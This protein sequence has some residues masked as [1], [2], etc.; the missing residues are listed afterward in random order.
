VPRRIQLADR[1]SHAIR[2]SVSCALVF[3]FPRRWSMSR[4]SRHV[5]A[6]PRRP[7]RRWRA[8]GAIRLIGFSGSS[9]HS[10]HYPPRTVPVGDVGIG[11]GVGDLGASAGSA[12]MN[13]YRPWSI[14]RPARRAWLENST[15]AS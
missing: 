9:R 2:A 15:I 7:A 4:P 12:A 13:K 3:P 10:R 5:G 11:N 6:S 1:G 14:D 8:R